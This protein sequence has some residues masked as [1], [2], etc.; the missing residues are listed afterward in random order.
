MS[1]AP[2]VNLIL[3]YCIICLGIISA[4][5]PHTTLNFFIR[6]FFRL[7]AALTGALGD[8]SGKHDVASAIYA[9]C[10]ICDKPVK[11]LVLA[12]L[13]SNKGPRAFSPDRGSTNQY[14]AGGGYYDKNSDRGFLDRPST[15]GYGGMGTGGSIGSGSMGFAAWGSSQNIPQPHSLPLSPSYSSNGL[16]LAG[17]IP[18]HSSFVPGNLRSSSAPDTNNNSE[19]ATP[20]GSHKAVPRV[21]TDYTVS[22]SLI[23]LPP[24]Q[25]LRTP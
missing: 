24:L 7:V 23:D 6:I 22:H 19:G 13:T 3:T 20:S 8:I 21:V 4:I 12:P 18:N 1:C 15:I 5:S 10:L 9:R 14:S 2:S 25:V 11:S 17:A 16:A